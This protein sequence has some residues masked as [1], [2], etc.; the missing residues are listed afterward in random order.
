[1]WPSGTAPALCDQAWGCS[2]LTFEAPRNTCSGRS[3]QIT[4]LVLPRTDLGA[5]LPRA[6]TPEMLTK[7]EANH[8]AS[9]APVAILSNYL[10]PSIFALAPNAASGGRL[11][12]YRQR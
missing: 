10:T 3:P 7:W 12:L 5:G 2:A 9:L 6:T 11:R 4:S 1:M 8:D